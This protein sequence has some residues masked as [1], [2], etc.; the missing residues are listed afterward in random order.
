MKKLLELT[1]NGETK[2]LYEH[3]KSL[4][5]FKYFVTILIAGNE[6]KTEF[7][8]FGSAFYFFNAR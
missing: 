8:D 1:N 3:E 7:N 5:G 6:I 4:T 2:K